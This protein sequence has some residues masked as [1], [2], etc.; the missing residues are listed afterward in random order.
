MSLWHGHPRN[1]GRRARARHPTIRLRGVIYVIYARTRHLYGCGAWT[2]TGSSPR[3]FCTASPDCCPAARLAPRIRAARRH[4]WAKRHLCEAM[5]GSAY[6][7]VGLGPRSSPARFDRRRWFGTRVCAMSSKPETSSMRGDVMYGPA[8]PG[9]GWRVW[10][11]LGEIR[12][13]GA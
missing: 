5:Y 8:H 9:M 7:R 13:P 2:S 10:R 12:Q 11:G 4:L 1:A 3:V 6:P